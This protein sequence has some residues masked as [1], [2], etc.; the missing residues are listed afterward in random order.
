MERLIDKVICVQ[1][2]SA[3]HGARFVDIVGKIIPGK[4][5]QT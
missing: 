4:V 1:R 3:S 5:S 2:P